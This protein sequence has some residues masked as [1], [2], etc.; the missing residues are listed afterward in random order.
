MP[1]PLEE[2]EPMFLTSSYVVEGPA[3]EQSFMTETHPRVVT[4]LG[5]G[6]YQ[7]TVQRTH[8]ITILHEDQNREY[9][10]NGMEYS[11]FSV[12][13]VSHK[14]IN[15][16]NCALDPSIPPRPLRDLAEERIWLTEVRKHQ[17]EVEQRNADLYVPI[18]GLVL[19]PQ[20][21]VESE[22]ALR[23]IEFDDPESG[24]F[25]REKVAAM[26]PII[27]YSGN[28]LS[29]KVRTELMQQLFTTS[30]DFDP[31]EVFSYIKDS[32]EFHTPRGKCTIEAVLQFRRDLFYDFPRKMGLVYRECQKGDLDHAQFIARQ[33]LNPVIAIRYELG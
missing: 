20:Y 32:A 8:A 5:E 30:R 24:V 23:D 2:Y 26:M 33:I 9:L 11:L 15:N 1:N 16:R 14:T 29:T 17:R 19:F 3:Y 31:E 21:T 4:V 13:P 10:A 27:S 12:V 6:N 22:A 7:R 28:A 25:Y 18:Q